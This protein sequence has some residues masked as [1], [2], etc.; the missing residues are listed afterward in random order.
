MFMPV[1][2]GKSKD[3][4]VKGQVREG[5][6]Y[7]AERFKLFPGK[8]GPFSVR[9]GVSGM[10]LSKISISSTEGEHACMIL[11]SQSQE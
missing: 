9:K 7:Q 3:K 6:S 4:N 1:E 2:V 8:W 10:N 5:L 11:Q